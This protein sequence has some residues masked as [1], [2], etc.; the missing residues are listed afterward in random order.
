MQLKPIVRKTEVAV[1]FLTAA[2]M[3]AATNAQSKQR[4]KAPVYRAFDG[5]T[6]SHSCDAAS[7]T[8]AGLKAAMIRHSRSLI[9]FK[10]KM[11]RGAFVVPKKARSGLARLRP[12]QIVE[13]ISSKLSKI[14]GVRRTSRRVGSASPRTPPRPP[15]ALPGAA[16]TAALIYD[17]GIAKGQYAL[18]VWL[19]SA[20][21]LE[22]AATVP[23]PPLPLADLVRT[24]MGVTALAQAR[25]PVRRARSKRKARKRSLKSETDTNSVVGFKMSL[26]D[27]AA[28]V[29]PPPIMA[30]LIGSRDEHRRR[31]TFNRIVILPAADIGTL[32]FAALPVGNK[33][34]MRSR[35]DRAAAGY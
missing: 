6:I 5:R 10:S 4:G 15:V 2:M 31:Q 17:V 18:C 3:F 24:G 33:R 22:A 8:A 28:L 23:L 7:G 12:A 29:L 30:K 27:A 9:G 32:P 35:G 25:M 11:R 16:R 13:R 21:G 14:D 20:S 19:V 34:L 1:V 26:A